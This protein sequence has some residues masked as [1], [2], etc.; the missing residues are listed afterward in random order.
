MNRLI[1]RGDVL[2]TNHAY[3]DQ[4]DSMFLSADLGKSHPNVSY[5]SMKKVLCGE[6]GDDCMVMVDGN[7][8]Y[9]DNGH[10]SKF[11]SEYVIN[12]LKSTVALANLE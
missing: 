6:Q 4:V 7:N 9:A 8:I 10:F 5:V 3:M 2:I 12:R 11:G 1:Y